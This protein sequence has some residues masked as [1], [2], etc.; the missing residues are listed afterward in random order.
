MPS[1]ASPWTGRALVLAGILLSALNLRT[2]VTSL[3]PLLDLLSVQFG[4]GPAVVGLFGMLPS[5]A[6]AAFGV[7][8]PRIA[9]RIGLE[10]AALLSMALAAAG[11]AARAFAAGVPTLMAGCIVALAGMGMGNVVLPPLVKRYFPRR[12]GT[13]SALY[14]TLLQLG[15]IVPALLAV[16]LAG[17]VGWRLSLGVW[18]LPALAAGLV[19]LGVLWRERRHDPVLA[20]V[21]DGAVRA[22]DA[23]PELAQPAVRLRP[24]RSP[25]AWGMTLMFGMTSLITYSMFTWLPTLMTEA[26]ASPAFGGTMVALFA[27]LGLGSALAMPAVA[28]RMRNPFPLVVACALAYAVAFPGLLLAPM[29]APVLWVVLLGI[30]PSTFP[31]SLTLINLRTRTPAGSATLSGFMQG[32]GY[33][34]AC[35]GPI[36]FGVL[37]DLRGGWGLPFA[38]LS[39]CALVMVA[40]SWQACRERMLEDEVAGPA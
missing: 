20:A 28:V 38:F 9:H 14:L 2:A 6:F 1:P 23:A 35:A 29:A 25:L 40:G 31:L 5:A 7:A 34:L 37:H 22:D 30:G 8:T 21:H 10:Q 32:V 39:L 17:A 18:T 13:V 24:W 16:P 36:L 4:F 27:A 33:T 11:L 3:T 26:G 12:V 19:W 15:T